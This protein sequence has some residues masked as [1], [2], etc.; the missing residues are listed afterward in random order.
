M[1]IS[2][3]LGIILLIIVGTLT[4]IGVAVIAAIETKRMEKGQSSLISNLSKKKDDKAEE[5]S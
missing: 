1:S 5:K 4:I 2:S 3:H